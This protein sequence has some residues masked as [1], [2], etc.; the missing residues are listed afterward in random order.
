MKH[1]ENLVQHTVLV[2]GDLILDEY[3]SGR[4]VRLSREAPVPVLERTRRTLVAGG[5]AN[6]AVNLARLGAEAW[7]AGVVGDDQQGRDL[8]DLL[9]RAGVHTEAVVRD[10]SRPTTTKTR[11]VAE[12]S[13]VH[14]QHLARIDH[15][16]RRPLDHP[17]ET[18]LVERLHHVAGRVNA[19]A[20]SNYRNGVITDG[21]IAACHAARAQHGVLL[22]VDSQG[23]LQRFRGFD[24][25]KC[26]RAEAESELGAHLPD[27]PAERLDAVRALRR[28][29]DAHWLV[30]TLGDEGMVWATPDA[31]GH[32]PP[33][34]RAT[35]YDVTGA[36]DT[37]L[38]LLTLA[39][40]AG[41]A[42]A[43][44]CHLANLAAG[45]VVQVLGNYAP[46]R[47]ELESLWQA[48]PTPPV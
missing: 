32:V 9:H 4:A 40:L 17:V 11:I 28:Q 27:A 8:L 7:V 24:V 42:P 43:D 6:P 48:H 30:V 44:A 38:A 33:A 36:G 22:C 13:F 10:P 29:C 14:G 12:G 1:L 5:A 34:R 46:T 31:A 45:L 39:R 20:V 15:L 19:I 47:D 2:L 26:N 41:L 23:G 21:V 16:D 35:V 18:L 3:L 37:V 25:V